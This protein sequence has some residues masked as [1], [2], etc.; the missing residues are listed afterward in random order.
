MR[1]PLLGLDPLQDRYWTGTT[2][3]VVKIRLL[4]SISKATPVNMD[5]AGAVQW[6]EPSKSSVL[7]FG[8]SSLM[9]S[10]FWPL[11][12]SSIV[13]S[14]ILMPAVFIN[15]QVTVVIS[16][17]RL[18]MAAPVLMPFHAAGREDGGVDGFAGSHSGDPDVGD[19]EAEDSAD[20]SVGDDSHRADHAV[21]HAT[22]RDRHFAHGRD[23]VH[24]HQAP[25]LVDLDT[26]HHRVHEHIEASIML[27]IWS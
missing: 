17:I 22:G 12:A 10:E 16:A 4:K 27:P 13:A 7:A 5:P 25:S 11:P 21:A 6:T 9:N 19:V 26:V 23:L 1:L 3:R 24:D 15:L 18:R 20:G 14:P 8:K 2:G